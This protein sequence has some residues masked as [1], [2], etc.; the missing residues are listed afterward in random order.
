MQRRWYLR[1]LLHYYSLHRRPR[2][3]SHYWFW[4]EAARRTVTP[5]KLH[6]VLWL[7]TPEGGQDYERAVAAGLQDW[8][9]QGS[10]LTIAER[11]RTG[12]LP[13]RARAAT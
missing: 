4:A 3:G 12:G 6:L 11:G 7:E 1:L 9:E 13:I 8:L 10:R 2:P 5:T